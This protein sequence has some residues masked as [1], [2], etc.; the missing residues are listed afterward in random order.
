M[1]EYALEGEMSRSGSINAFLLLPCH[2]DR[3]KS[4]ADL[5]GYS[6]EHMALRARWSVRAPHPPLSLRQ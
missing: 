3:G 5:A 2:K 6:D 1:A 4:A